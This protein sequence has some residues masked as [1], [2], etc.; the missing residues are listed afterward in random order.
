MILD[1]QESESTPSSPS[2]DM[3]VSR[4]VACL[5]GIAG[6]KSRMSPPLVKNVDKVINE[7]PNPQ[8]LFPGPIIL[9]LPNFKCYEAVTFPLFYP[10]QRQIVPLGERRERRKD[11]RET[12]RR[13]RAFFGVNV[14]ACLI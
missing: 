14:I 8:A 11:L 5:L 3:T 2:G 7:R 13:P 1:S 10:E 9:P 12:R 6:S 4:G